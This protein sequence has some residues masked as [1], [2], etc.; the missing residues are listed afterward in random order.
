MTHNM[1]RSQV[2]HDPVIGQRIKEVREKN[3]LTQGQFADEIEKEIKIRYDQKTI[4]NW[5]KHGLNKDN[6]LSAISK[7]F[8]VPLSYLKN[9][10]GKLK[11]IIENQNWLIKIKETY[12]VLM[13][14][15]AKVDDDYFVYSLDAQETEALINK[16]T[17]K[18]AMLLGD[19]E[20]E[21]AH[22]RKTI[23]LRLILDLGNVTRISPNVLLDGMPLSEN[24]LELITMVI[25]GI[26]ANRKDD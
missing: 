3:G 9:E 12:N 20:R 23:D 24:E 18:L 22:L 4:S 10:D 13:K 1:G 25:K 19:K 6:V 8:N 7:R 11:E 2:N 17:S 26:H 21:I 14:N 15:T 16:D 5:E